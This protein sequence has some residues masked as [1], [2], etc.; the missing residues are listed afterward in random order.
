M[1]GERVEHE[2]KQSKENVEGINNRSDAKE[3]GKE[4]VNR[5]KKVRKGASKQ[6]QQ[7]ARRSTVFATILDIYRTEGPA[8]LYEGVL[9]E[10]LKGLF[11]H[12]ITM[13][14]KE[15]IHKLIIQTYFLI[16]KTLN[17]S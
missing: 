6:A 8:A 4:E 5:L 1:E 2:C 3:I 16:L 17:K 11:S 9:G 7:I 15:Q 14:V 12:G 13:T 10:I